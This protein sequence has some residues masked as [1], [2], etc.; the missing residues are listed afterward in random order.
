MAIA[1]KPNGLLGWFRRTKRQATD[2]PAAINPPPEPYIDP[3]LLKRTY[4]RTWKRPGS[5][6]IVNGTVW[7][8]SGYQW[9]SCAPHWGTAHVHSYATSVI[10]NELRSILKDPPATHSAE[11][12][13]EYPQQPS[14]LDS[15]PRPEQI[16]FRY[17]AGPLVGRLHTFRPV[18]GQEDG[19]AEM[20]AF[21]E[22]LLAANAI[23]R[24]C[25]HPVAP[26]A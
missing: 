15:Q 22:G 4:G 11:L 18:D 2:A 16:V 25:H 23:Q 13:I 14:L 5:R 10:G 1:T 17:T 21:A 20:V 6:T 3:E 26:S 8:G 7:I 19:W 9:S 12:V 24:I